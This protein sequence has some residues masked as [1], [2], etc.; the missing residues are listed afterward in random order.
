M[1]GCALRLQTSAYAIVLAPLEEAADSAA[2]V[3]YGLG[4]RV[5]EL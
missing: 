1:Q 4:L 5:S 3:P 2:C